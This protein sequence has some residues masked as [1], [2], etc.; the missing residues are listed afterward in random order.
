VFLEPSWWP[1]LLTILVIKILI[2]LPIVMGIGK[3][4]NRPGI[5]I[6]SIPLV[7]LYPIYIVLIGA[8]GILG[9]YNWKGRKVKN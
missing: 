1:V 6:F 4:V 2:D 3:F 9:N 8:L 5:I 7:V